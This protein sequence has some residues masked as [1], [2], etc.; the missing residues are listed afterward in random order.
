MYQSA[1]ENK[2]A[3]MISALGITERGFAPRV[4]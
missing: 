3:R 4:R 2:R 1:H